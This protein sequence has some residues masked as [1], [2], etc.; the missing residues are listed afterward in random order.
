M[1]E[2]HPIASYAHGCYVTSMNKKQRQ[3]YMDSEGGGGG[4][5]ALSKP[6]NYS[7][8]LTSMS[9]RDLSLL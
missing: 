8:A 3:A 4:C 9:F 2:C 5:V 1:I 7:F 6:S